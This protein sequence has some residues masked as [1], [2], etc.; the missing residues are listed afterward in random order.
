MRRSLL[1]LVACVPLTLLVPACET[2]VEPFAGTVTLEHGGR[3]RSY[4]LFV[5]EDLTSGPDGVPL[6][7][8]MHG[9]FGDPDTFADTTRFEELAAREGF[10]VAFPAGTGR[11]PDDAVRSWNAGAC[12]GPAQANQVDDV[13]F[14]LAVVDDVAGR[15]PVDTDRVFATGH[16]NGARMAYRL[17]CEA[18]D[19]FA[20]IG[21]VA[22]E[23]DTHPCEP[24]RPVS[25]LHIHGDADPIHPIDGSEPSVPFGA[26]VFT[27][28]VDTIDTWVALDGCPALAVEVTSGEV[29]TTTWDGC[30]DGTTVEYRIVHGG[31]HSWPGSEPGRGA[32]IAG[33][34]SPALDATA[35]ITGFLLSHPR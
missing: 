25:V 17:A 3:E 6:V 16:S 23:L 31:S 13:G 9:G 29:T 1:A 19:T 18:A 14:L 11:P 12:C 24:S 2:P 10:V 35:V 26:A 22:G 15:V 8:A 20:A 30:T 27:P 33:P 4:R 28:I 32:A 5:P 7:V 21:V 34:P